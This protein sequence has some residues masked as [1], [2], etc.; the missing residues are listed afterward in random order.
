MTTTDDQETGPDPDDSCCP[1]P[2]TP[3]ASGPPVTCHLKCADACFHPVPNTSENEYFR[4]I[5]SASMTRR[6]VLWG[7]VAAGGAIVVGAALGDAQPAAAWGRPSPRLAFTPIA[8]V[9]AAVDSFVV[10]DGLPVVADHPLGRPAV[11]R[12]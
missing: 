7:A 10:P 11:L 9:P 3:R 6:S 4:D 2:G 8:P 12:A 1:W 5:A